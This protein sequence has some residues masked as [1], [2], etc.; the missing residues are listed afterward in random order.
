MN[1]AGLG[2]ALAHEL[3]EVLAGA[4]DS[5]ARD[6]CDQL[7]PLAGVCEGLLDADSGHMV[8]RDPH[9]QACSRIDCKNSAFQHFHFY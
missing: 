2:C 4:L 3:A 6:G 8:V 1:R 7:V 9:D 5:H